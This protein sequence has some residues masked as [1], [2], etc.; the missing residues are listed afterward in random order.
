MSILPIHYKL[1]KCHFFHEEFL[2]SLSPTN[3]I[4]IYNYHDNSYH[5]STSCH[6]LITVPK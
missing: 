3:L 1:L 2:D 6:A 4:I 5:L